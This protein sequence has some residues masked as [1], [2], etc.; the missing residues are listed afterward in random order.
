MTNKN[1]CAMTVK[2][3]IL[4]MCQMK[5]DCRLFDWLGIIRSR[6]TV[7]QNDLFFRE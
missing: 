7:Y 4:P 3:K 5:L 1:L 6:Y 2:R